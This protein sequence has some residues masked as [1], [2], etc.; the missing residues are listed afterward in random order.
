MLNKSPDSLRII[1][2]IMA[3][4]ETCGRAFAVHAWH[5]L[6]PMNERDRPVHSGN[7]AVP[8]SPTRVQE[9]NQN[10]RVQARRITVG[11]L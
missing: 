4:P 9:P 6:G 8:K 11:V 10:P 1:I 3:V 7:R 5:V 2:I